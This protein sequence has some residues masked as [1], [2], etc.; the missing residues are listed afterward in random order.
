MST[1]WLR[2]RLRG[3]GPFRLRRLTRVTLRLP[4]SCYV[5]RAEFGFK[6]LHFLE[7]CNSWSIRLAGSPDPV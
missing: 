1:V 3:L 6:I 7:L 2:A 4:S 5:D